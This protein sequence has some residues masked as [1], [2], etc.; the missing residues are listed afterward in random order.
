MT[1]TSTLSSRFEPSRS[2]SCSCSTR[3]TLACVFRLMSAISSRKI[4][5]LSAC[6]NLPIC[7]LGGAGERALLVAEE[8]RLDQLVGD[9]RAVHLHEGAVA[10]Q[11]LAV[12]GPRH[13]LLADP[14]LAPD[15][16]RGVGR[17]RLARWPRAPRPG[18]RCRRRSDD[19]A[20]GPCGTTRFSVRSR[21][22]SSALRTSTSRRSVDERLLD[23]VEGAEA[24]RLDRGL[25]VGVAR[26]H[27]DRGDVG[28]RPQPLQ[29][30]EAVHARHLDV[31]EDQVGRLRAR[32]APRPSS[33]LAASITA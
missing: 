15:E 12:H 23:D 21:R 28:E 16:H 27:D 18:R 14:A 8:L 24:G 7:S 32:P 29:H 3:S 4:V 31:E 6:S 9:R 11:A 13:Q 20:P 19:G 5:P 1:R 30:L 25:D 10:A 33:P 17:R 26:Q 22:E 2:S